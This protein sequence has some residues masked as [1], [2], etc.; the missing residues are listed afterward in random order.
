MSLHVLLSEEKPT[1]VARWLDL[2]LEDYPPETVRFLKGQRDQFA[3]PVGSVFRQAIADLYEE[4]IGEGDPGRAVALL[5]PILRIRAVQ[6]LP[7]SRALAF[8]PGLKQV[9]REAV[10]SNG[11][12]VQPPVRPEEWRE[13]D[14]R[15]DQLTLLA[16][17]VY[18]GCREK[19]HEIRFTE[20]RNRT[21]LLLERA[22]LVAADASPGGT[23]GGALSPP[24]GVGPQAGQDGRGGRRAEEGEG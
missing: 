7:A 3:N 1:V 12:S 16:F 10:G 14:D 15:I 9:V 20:L 5:D 11:R 21:H 4:L 2:L 24:V 23:P 18:L 13:L 6:D 8:L 22:G 19:I 17:D